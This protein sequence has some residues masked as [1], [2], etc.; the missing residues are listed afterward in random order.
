MRW[1][2]ARDP[3]SCTV[4]GADLDRGAVWCGGC[5]ARVE[6]GHRA[7]DVAPP[8][9]EDLPRDAPRPW[10]DRTRVLAAVGLLGVLLAVLAAALLRPPPA[11]P[12]L[13]TP[14]GAGGRSA[15]GPPPGGLQRAWSSPLAGDSGPP[16]VFG[17]VTLTVRDGRAAVD[18]AV[19]ALDRSAAVA[20][21]PSV[22]AAGTDGTGV[23]VLGEEVVRLDV[24][25]GTVLGRTA[26]PTPL[27]DAVLPVVRT[28]EVTVLT[29]WDG[30]EDTT[31]LLR[32]DGEVL[33]RHLGQPSA[34]LDRA[35]D[36]P[37]AVAVRV[38]PGPSAAATL[39]ATDDGR[40]LTELPGGTP[41]VVDVVGER[42]LVAS[43]VSDDVGGPGTGVLW[44]VQLLDATD[45]RLLW[46]TRIVSAV[47]PR[48]L[49]RAGEGDALLVTRSGTEV[50]VHRVDEATDAGA[51][52]VAQLRTN[53]LRS[54]PGFD[55]TFAASVSSMLRAVAADEDVVV[56]HDSAAEELRAVT[57]DGAELWRRP[58]PAAAGIAATDGV[59]ALV[60]RLGD[61]AVRLL[62]T[63]DGADLA[64]VADVDAGEAGTWA[65]AALLGRDL[66]LAPGPRRGRVEL[67]V[68]SATWVDVVTGER[69]TAAEVLGERTQVEEPVT[70]GWRLVG[71]LRDGGTGPA[72]PV[73]LRDLGRDVVQLLVPGTGFQTVDLDLPDEGDV[74]SYL[75]FVVGT[76]ATHVALR[77]DSFEGP[78]AGVTHV[79]DR[80]TTEAA[81]HLTG[82][83]GLALRDELLLGVVPDEQG[84]W[85][86]MVG[87]DP[88][89]GERSWRRDLPAAGRRLVDAIDDELV[90]HVAPVGVEATSLADGTTAWQ[91][92]AAVA[93][94]GHVVLGP[95]HATV[96]T[97]DGDVVAL[98][99]RDGTE[100]WRSPLGVRVTALTGAG[101]DLLV[102]TAD[103]LVVHL[104]A[105]GE[106][107]QRLVVG[108]GPVRAVA[109]LGDT[110]VAV[111]DGTAV[112]LRADGTGLAPGD[113]V[114]LP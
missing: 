61:Q 80:T 86:A 16:R 57:A 3:G 8:V 93:L 54:G 103:G 17:T 65:P 67:S 72:E 34:G 101:E 37:M 55:D 2:F 50:V 10:R 4:C 66:A 71:V 5:G 95:A 53:V 98:H 78:T 63:G 77:T 38:A 112:G 70:G 94:T 102:G 36:D 14:D 114:E 104:D 79:V 13:G 18:G 49:G 45:G 68:G 27:A 73:V 76:T 51:E 64:T 59:V 11:V 110:V 30:E 48:L 12:L 113:E 69:R 58:A 29:S 52:V 26:L 15:S 42:A 111:A 84:S 81:V 1:S 24:L 47:A 56:L 19:V 43:A 28:G 23:L 106:E 7:R 107:V 109:A 100:A 87:H 21:V 91:H 62:R 44:S 39:V 99:R 25:D 92:A 35:V 46:R 90:L 9:E 82:V 6:D 41:Q 108:T 22:D 20:S 88:M 89:T 74:A 33:A 105:R 32:D 40:V 83:V 75:S 96:V 85:V 97:V 60:P 31:L